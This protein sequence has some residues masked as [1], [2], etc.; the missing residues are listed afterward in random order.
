MQTRIIR[1]KGD[2]QWVKVTRKKE[3]II[4]EDANLISQMKDL[5]AKVTLFICAKS[6]RVMEF[7]KVRIELSYI[8]GCDTSRRH[9]LFLLC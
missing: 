9:R 1:V 5:V 2:K 7:I 8:E 4:V 3:D 6:V